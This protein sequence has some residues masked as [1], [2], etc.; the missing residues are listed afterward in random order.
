MELL[1][2]VVV[3]ED[4][5]LGNTTRSL[6]RCE[7]GILAGGGRCVLVHPS[8]AGQEPVHAD[9]RIMERHGFEEIEAGLVPAGQDVGNPGARDAQRIG[10]LRLR[11]ILSVQELLEAFVHGEFDKC[12]KSNES[13]VKI[14]VKMCRERGRRRGENRLEYIEV[15]I[16]LDIIKSLII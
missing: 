16:S 14:Q 9:L 15:I 8:F 2:G 11:D 4:E 10:E 12:Y 3:I 13:K 5:N 6:H 1:E 7:Y